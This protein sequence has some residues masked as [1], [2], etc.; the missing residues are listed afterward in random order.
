MTLP[1]FDI[2]GWI[3]TLSEIEKLNFSQALFAHNAPNGLPIGTKADITT[4]REYV[5]D[6]IIAVKQALQE[7]G[8]SAAQNVSLPKYQDW[9]FYEEWL[10]LNALSI[11]FY[12]LLGL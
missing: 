3:Y 2:D 12:L 8:F 6:L 4:Q 9:G 11:Q 5:E 1:D 10:P 7:Y